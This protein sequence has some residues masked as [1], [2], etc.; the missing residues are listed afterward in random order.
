MA[1][2]NTFGQDAQYDTNQ[3]ATIGYSE[4]ESGFF[5]NSCK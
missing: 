5:S 1:N 4:F 2:G 3:F